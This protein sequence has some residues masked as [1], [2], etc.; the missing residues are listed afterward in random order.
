MLKI[1]ALTPK[2]MRISMH[3]HS[4][5]TSNYFKY[6]TAMLTVTHIHTMPFSTGLN[7]M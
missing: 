7:F 2:I 5:I 6:V 3:E 4:M 1:I